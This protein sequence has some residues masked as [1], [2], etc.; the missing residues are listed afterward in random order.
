MQILT[1]VCLPN[2]GGGENQTSKKKSKFALVLHV[3]GS[4]KDHPPIPTVV[5][6]LR[7]KARAFEGLRQRC[8]SLM[9]PLRS[10]ED[11]QK[12][13]AMKAASMSS[14]T[15]MAKISRSEIPQDDDEIQQDDDEAMEEESDGE[16]DTDA[17]DMFGGKR[18]YIVDLFTFSRSLKFYEPV[19]IQLL[20]ASASTC[21]VIV[22]STAH[23]SSAVQARLLNQEVF[24]AM[25]SSNEHSC[26]HGV[27]IQNQIFRHLFLATKGLPVRDGACNRLKVFIGTL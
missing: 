24:L 11:R 22:T 6:A 8:L 27:Q 10:M 20:N 21:C 17:H 9:C 1:R 14:A 5:P 26:E 16:M 12:A 3:G 2:A 25:P 4:V 15:E 23:P 7:G 18:D 19:M 13:E